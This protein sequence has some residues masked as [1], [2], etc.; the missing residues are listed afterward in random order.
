VGVISRKRMICRHTWVVGQP[1]QLHVGPPTRWGGLLL[2]SIVSIQSGGMWQNRPNE[3]IFRGTCLLLDIK[4]RESQL[5][6]TVPSSTP[7]N[8]NPKQSIILHP[9][10]NNE[11]KLTILSSFLTQRVSEI[12]Y[13]STKVQSAIIKQRNKI[14][15]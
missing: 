14:N 10:S 13:Y 8:E 2:P 15:I 7:Q 12:L 5:N 3:H 4:Y 6:Q 11:Y 1:S 9:G